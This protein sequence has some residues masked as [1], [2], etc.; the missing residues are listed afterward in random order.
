MTETGG[1][2]L[3][4]LPNGLARVALIGAMLGLAGSCSMFGGGDEKPETTAAT[5]S[6]TTPAS[7][8]ASDGID[9]RRYLGPNYCPELRVVNGAE[10]VRRYER[11][12]EEDPKYV[13]WQAS[14][15][16]TAR[17]CLYDAQ[18]GLTLKIG[19]SGRVIAGP[20]GGPA[21]TVAVPLKIAVVKHRE[22]VLAT[23]D[24][25][26][27]VVLPA[28]GSSVFTQV[29][30]IVVPSPG[31]DRDY[32]VYVGFDTGGWDVKDGEAVAVEKPPPPRAAPPPAPAPAPAPAQPTT[33][34]VL[35]T[36]S[37]G[38]VLPQ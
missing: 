33:P 8:D 22:K 38:F 23:E 27:D 1:K 18:G 19:V 30:Q 21:A 29:K 28:Q 34:K 5:T 35:P 9:I 37:D 20:K 32:V 3:A 12:H 17:E 26:Q 14:F 11:G 2:I 15:G 4:A 10:L 7:A 24:F 6:A 16:K 25:S 13:I 36:P 31:D